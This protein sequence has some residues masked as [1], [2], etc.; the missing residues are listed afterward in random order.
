MGWPLAVFV[1][2]IVVV[3][4]PLAVA[5]STVR[6]SL[7]W[8][9]RAFLAAMAPRGIVAASV[10]SVFAIQ[11]E[12]N[13][14]AGAELLVPIT[15][16]AIIATVAIYGLPARWVGRALNV[17]EPDP[18]GLLIVGG[19][20]VGIA[21]GQ[22]VQEAGIKVR[23]LVGNRTDHYRA[24]MAGLDAVYANLL[25]SHE[26]DDLI[27]AGIGQALAVTHNDE[28]NSLAAVHL[29]ALMGPQHVYQL[30]PDR[31]SDSGATHETESMLRGRWLF[32]MDLS[33]NQ[34]HQRLDDGWTI[35]TTPL[36]EAFGP[37][38]F[39]DVHGPEATPLFLL[40]P[41][42]IL[43]VVTADTDPV[44]HPGTTVLA[45]VPPRPA[46]DEEEAA[47]AERSDAGDSGESARTEAAG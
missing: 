21:L 36:T 26:T 23:V 31:D 34:I 7:D 3:A 15:F 29:A 16:A 18:Q 6:S 42:G 35:S 5:A 32:E 41:T 44:L 33:H 25:A 8:N 19:D 38:D 40:G 46:G 47:R 22:A 39:L 11:L 45:L 30:V 27:P 1:A 12:A 43:T 10:A 17:A 9:E 14:I 24:R 2:I 4:R 37:A 20:A 28:Y 13:Q